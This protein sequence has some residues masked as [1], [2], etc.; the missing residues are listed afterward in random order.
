MS[1][2]RKD[3]KALKRAFRKLWFQG[4]FELEVIDF[5][6]LMEMEGANQVKRETISKMLGYRGE[7]LSLYTP[8]ILIHAH[9]VLD[10]NG[11]AAD[12]V[13]SWLTRR[14]SKAERQ[15]HWKRIWQDQTLEDLCWKLGSYPFKDRVQ[16]N[17]TFELQDYRNGGYFSDSREAY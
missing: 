4:V 2:G 13:E 12:K 6:A 7:K 1:E 14:I 16:F 10:L 8:L 9:L 17:T 15:I 11:E 3:L 5:K